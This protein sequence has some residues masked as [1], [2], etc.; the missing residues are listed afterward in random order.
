VIERPVRTRAQA[1]ALRVPDWEEEAPE[2]ATAIRLIRSELAGKV[3][4]IGFAGAPFTLASYLVEIKPARDLARTRAFMLREPAAWRTLMDR[5]SASLLGWL[6]AQ[7]RAGAQ[8]VQLFDSWVGC[9][10]PEDY[11]TR[12]LPWS[13]RIFA[14]LADLG[15]PRIH[16][17]TGATGLLEQMAEAGADVVGVDWR[18]PLDEARWRLGPKI[19]VQGNLDPV[20]LL[21]PWEQAKKK[22]EDVLRRG[23]QRR[24]HVFNLGHGVLP[25]T[26]VEHLQRLVALVHGES[27]TTRVGAK[28]RGN[29]RPPR[30]VSGRR[31]V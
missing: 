22:A 25:D 23:A 13:R 27:G 5:L 2:V 20:A 26:P 9:L 6:R 21:G 11:E 16:F 17:G 8:A 3:P 30:R 19:A 12:V 28:V 4:L 14:G 24:G 18:V 1:A 7:V 29:R 31:R 15:V 10:S